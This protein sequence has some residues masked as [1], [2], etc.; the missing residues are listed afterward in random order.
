MRPPMS[1]RRHTS[2]H[3]KAALPS[4]HPASLPS[5]ERY[6]TC[7]HNVEGCPMPADGC[8]GGPLVG[9]FFTKHKKKK[10][11]RKAYGGEFFYYFFLPPNEDEPVWRRTRVQP[12]AARARRQASART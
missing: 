6:H 4:G 5:D 1:R 3:R 2:S 10:H 7:A 11:G 9:P 12:L 8:G